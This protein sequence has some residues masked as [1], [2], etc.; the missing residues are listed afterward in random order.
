MTDRDERRAYMRGFDVGVHYAVQASDR[1]LQAAATASTLAHFEGQHERERVLDRMTIAACR[2]QRR[3]RTD[4]AAAEAWTIE[5][6]ER[7]L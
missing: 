1:L 7:A 2:A 4:A 6:L 5:Q 3:L